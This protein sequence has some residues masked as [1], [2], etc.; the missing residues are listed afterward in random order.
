LAKWRSTF[1]FAKAMQGDYARPH[2]VNIDGNP[3]T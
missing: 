3:T 2:D 1:D